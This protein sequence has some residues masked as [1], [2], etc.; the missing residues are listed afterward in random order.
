MRVRGR[1]KLAPQRGVRSLVAESIVA[2]T[3]RNDEA[4]HAI[5]CAE[6]RRTTYSHPVGVAA[7]ELGHQRAARSSPVRPPPEVIV[8]GDSDSDS[9]DTTIL[10]DV[11][12]RSARSSVETDASSFDLSVASR[13]SMSSYARS[14]SR[15]PRRRRPG[16]AESSRLANPYDLS[17]D[18]LRN[19]HQLRDYVVDYM[20]RYDRLEPTRRFT[21]ATLRNHPGLQRVAT[22]VAKQTQR[23]LR[24]AQAVRPLSQ[25]VFRSLPSSQC[26]TAT[27]LGA[28]P[29]P[30][31]AAID[32]RFQATI[33]GLLETGLVVLAE[34]DFFGGGDEAYQLFTPA[35]VE[36]E[37]LR[38]GRRALER[39]ERWTRAVVQAIKR[40]PIRYE[41]LA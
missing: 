24:E 15:S 4:R 28:E 38:R 7:R 11:C 2:C 3:D 37:L 30:P 19:P 35:L 18:H 5:R 33:R 41:F 40:E 17:A 34:E 21:F 12:G 1:V 32:R 22:L 23:D 8:I 9:N 29:E 26:A 13:S 6:L 36:P 14:P 39:D 16:Q 20:A 27:D 25:G 10:A 31:P